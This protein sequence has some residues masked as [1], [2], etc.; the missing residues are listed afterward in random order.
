M[1]NYTL[2]LLIPSLFFFVS[3]CNKS[4]AA[5]EKNE[6]EKTAEIATDSVKKKAITTIDTADYNKQ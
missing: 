1:K 2:A 3:S 6:V 5:D 4:K